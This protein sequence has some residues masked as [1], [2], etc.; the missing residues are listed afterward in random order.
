VA[1]RGKGNGYGNGN[2]N[3]NGNGGQ[4][5]YGVVQ[6]SDPPVTARCTGIL[7]A[8]ATVRVRLSVADIEERRLR[9]EL[10][11]G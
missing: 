2:G 4:E 10:A 8:G 6:L 7:E 11:D 5:P 9:F 1:G 3:G